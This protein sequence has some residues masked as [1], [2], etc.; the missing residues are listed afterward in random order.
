MRDIFPPPVDRWDAPA[1]GPLSGID[2][3]IYRAHA[4]GSDPAL[5]KE[6]GGN[7][8][9]KGYADDHRGRRTRVLWMSAWGCDGATAAAGEFPALRLDDLLAVRESPIPGGRPMMDYTADCGLRGE[10]LRPGIETLL[11]AFIPAGHVDHCHPDAVIALTS[12]PGG[13]SAAEAEFGDEAIWFDYR[14]FDL[15][16]AR[17]LAGRI[18][19]NHRARFVLLAN[20]GLLTW[21]E[22]S[23]ECYRNSIEAVTRSANAVAKSLLG[24]LDLGG[25]AVPPLPPDTAEERLFRILPAIRGALGTGTPGVILHLDQSADAVRFASSKR[26]PGWSQ[27]GP[28]CP[29]HVNTTGY[30]PLITDSVPAGPEP[31]LAGIRQYQDWYDRFFEQY[32][33]AEGRALGKRGNTPRVIVLPGLGVVSS[34]PNAAKAR[35]CA[36]HFAQSMTVIRAADAAGGYQSLSLRQGAADEYWPLM[37]S[38]PQFK[39]PEG[40]LAGKVLLVADTDADRA[41]RVADR[42]ARDGAHV[43]I[44]LPDAMAAAVAAREITSRHGERRATA[45]RLTGNPQDAVRDTVANY[46]GFDALLHMGA[47]DDADGLLGAALPVFARQGTSGSILLAS[48]R[49]AEPEIRTRIRSMED[50]EADVTVT[51]IPTANPGAIAKMAA[52]FLSPEL[53]GLANRT[54]KPVPPGAGSNGQRKRA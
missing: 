40:E 2:E 43:S 5:T 20:H 29:D 26:G 18:E 9:A 12:F 47:R 53:T 54:R 10:Q 48:G 13:K 32:V 15:D 37:R 17:E 7:F 8:S 44:A 21:A 49:L 46:G 24:P 3:V 50:L 45:V 34:G 4:V 23:E 19:A 42:L 51:A 31:V 52:L 36:D 41:A 39:P 6:G 38:K 35:L 11:H 14:Q 25:P 16:V 1:A 33:P 28:G 22:T 27:E 30:R